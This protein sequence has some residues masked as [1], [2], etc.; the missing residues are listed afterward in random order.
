MG[1]IQSNCFSALLPKSL[2]VLDPGNLSRIVFSEFLRSPA[3]GL[4]QRP[5][6]GAKEARW[7]TLNGEKETRWRTWAEFK[8][9]FVL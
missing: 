7:R 6:N 5:L 1:S 8:A 4:L 2:K 3:N 9:A